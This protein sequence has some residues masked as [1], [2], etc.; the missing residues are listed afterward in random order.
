MDASSEQRLTWLN[1]LPAARAVAELLRCCGARRWAEAMAARRPFASLQ[2][3]Q[4][5]AS[6][7]WW[8]LERADWLEAFAA[9]P[10]IGDLQRLRERFAGRGGSWSEGEQAGVQGA[11]EALLQELMAGNR[12]YERR[13]GHIFIVCASGRTA[14]ELLQALRA[15]LAN[16][17]ETE[18]RLAAAE[19]DRITRLR[20]EKLLQP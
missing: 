1:A 16:D 15:R 20:L 10:R 14:A 7:V 19:Q 17:P 18:L 12:E 9:H 13:F 6:E 8:A 3:L 2:A 4:Q 11:P 5:A